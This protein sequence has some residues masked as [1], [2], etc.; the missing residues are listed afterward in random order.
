MATVAYIVDDCK[1]NNEKKND[2]NTELIVESNK[3]EGLISFDG[4]LRCGTAS[5]VINWSYILTR[6]V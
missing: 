1:N 2:N 5:Y 6:D 4:R 3:H